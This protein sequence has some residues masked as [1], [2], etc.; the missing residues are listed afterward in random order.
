ML[1]FGGVFAVYLGL[2]CGIR[3]SICSDGLAFV[4]GLSK[5]SVESAQC[6]EVLGSA[7]AIWSIALYFSVTVVAVAGS[8]RTT[9]PLQL[10]NE[11][12]IRG[13]DT[14]LMR[15]IQLGDELEAKAIPVPKKS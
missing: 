7:R 2:I 9:I 10:A 14:L 8:L 5:R 1:V 4:R 13:G 12:S 15:L 11:L 6:L 3:W